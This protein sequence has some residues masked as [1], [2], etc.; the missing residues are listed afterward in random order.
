MRL[1]D[2]DALIQNIVKRLCIR[3]EEYL[4]EQELVIV[5]EI[6]NAPTIE[7]K[8]EWIPVSERLPDASG[9]YLCTVNRYYHFVRQMKFELLEGDSYRWL[10]MSGA[11]VQKKFVIAWKPLPEPYHS[12]EVTEMV[13][14]QTDDGTA[15]IKRHGLRVDYGNEV[16]YD[17]KPFIDW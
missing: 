1:I 17:L 2:A 9:L 5:S 6:Y 15:F 4:T 16:P 10:L 13:K 12:G 7:P 8:Q 3:S 11:E 14:P